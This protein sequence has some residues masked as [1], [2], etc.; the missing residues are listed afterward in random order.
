MPRSARTKSCNGIY[1]CIYRGIDK[2]DIF[3]DNQD[4]RKFLEEMRKTKEK[5]EYKIYAYC[6]MD[7]H[8]H[9]LIRDEKN[10][11][12][13]IMQS[14]AVGYAS[15]FN[16]K[17]ERIGHLFQNRYL[18]KNVEN[19]EYFLTLHRY[20]HQNPYDME[21]YI[22]SSFREYLYESDLVD[23]EFT[24]KIFGKTE[25]IAKEKFAMFVT[26][27]NKRTML[28]EMKDC[29]MVKELADSQVIEI[30]KNVTDSENIFKIKEFSKEKREEYIRK[31][32]EIE[33]IS[34]P[35]L[36]RILGLNKKMIQRIK[37]DMSQTGQNVPM[38]TVPNGTKEVQNG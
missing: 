9:M 25:N 18:S 34:K 24:L 36:A 35:Q 30:I 28:K 27:R 11:I 13:K 14:L 38:G 10:V 17:Y 4:R 8:V 3:L 20:I 22:W 23:T 2:Q 19:L 33:G 12:G 37:V 31:L 1:H 5:Y 26:K 15:Y 32:L 7:N 21:H 29:E 16:K 6:L